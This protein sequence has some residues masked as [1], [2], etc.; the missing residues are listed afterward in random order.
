LQ[1]RLLHARPLGGT[2]TRN[3]ANAALGCFQLGL[4]VMHNN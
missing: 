2:A 1:E 4:V 3:I